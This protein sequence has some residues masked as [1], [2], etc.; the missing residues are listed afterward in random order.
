MKKVLSLIVL[1]L[2]L[3]A[4]SGCSENTYDSIAKKQ[5]IEK[6]TNIAITYV[7][8][9]ENKDI[10]FVSSEFEQDNGKSL[11]HLKGYEKLAPNKTIKMTVDY[12]KDFQIVKK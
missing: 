3:L 9:M 7:K 6:A 1:I 11:I 2:T 8:R 12:N 5:V 10:V 4:L